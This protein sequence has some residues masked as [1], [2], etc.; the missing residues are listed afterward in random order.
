MSFLS[1]FILVCTLCIFH[2][3]ANAFLDKMPVHL[4]P[5]I[6]LEDDLLLQIQD[7][8]GSAHR[9][10]SE[11]R[12]EAITAAL[13]PIFTAM[14]KNEYDKLGSSATSYALYRVFVARHAWFATGLEPF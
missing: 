7:V 4:E 1:M 11:Q 14:P 6:E 12:L 2:S 5:H 9:S 3:D 13:R 10:F 8:L